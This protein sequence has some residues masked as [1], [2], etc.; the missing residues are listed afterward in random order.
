MASVKVKYRKSN[1]PGMTGIIYYQLIVNR[2]VRQI[3]TSYRLYSDEWSESG[4]R[5]RCGKRIDR[6][7][8]IRSIETSVRCDI[9]RFHKIIFEYSGRGVPLSA[10]IL[11]DEYSR[12]SA[13]GDIFKFMERIVSRMDN[14]NKNRTSEA[15]RAALLS[16]RKFRADIPLHFDSMTAELVEGYQAWLLARDI[17]LNTVSFYMRILRAVYNRACE[18]G[19]TSDRHPFRHVYTGVAKTVKRAI[20]FSDI[21]KISALD[22]TSEPQ[23]SQARDVFMFLFITRGM[24]MIDAAFLKKSDLRNGYLS[25]RRHKTGQLL[26]IRWEKPMQDI[27]NRISDPASPYLLNL[28]DYSHSDKRKNYLYIIGRINGLL[29]IIAKRVGLT[30]PLTTYVARHTWASVARNR[31]IPLSII[32]QGMGHDSEL[33]TRIYLASLD[34]SYIDR[35]NAQILKGLM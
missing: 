28:L 24:S 21:K 17:S 12:L 3:Q 16:F 25:Y 1:V 26:T 14:C 22:L 30:V 31:N 33:T 5:I 20:L 9:E 34:T 8:K 18:A 10:D 7:D 15:Y 19:L 4:S 11:A 2:V 13:G 29:K 6:A 35:A 27:V 32:S 23:L